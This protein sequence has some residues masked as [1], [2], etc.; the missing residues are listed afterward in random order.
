MGT[1]VNANETSVKRRPV[2]LKKPPHGFPYFFILFLFWGA[3]LSVYLTN[4]V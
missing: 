3:Y 1:D 4:P 2:Y